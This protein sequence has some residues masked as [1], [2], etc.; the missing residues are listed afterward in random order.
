M[1]GEKS[2]RNHPQNTSSGEEV[3]GGA[4]GIREDTYVQP[5]EETSVGKAF[6]TSGQR[7][8]MLVQIST[9]QP[10]KYL[11]PEHVDIP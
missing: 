4:P 9:L 2:V 5:M 7:G 3:E 6:P 1:S 10:M 11:I 8:S